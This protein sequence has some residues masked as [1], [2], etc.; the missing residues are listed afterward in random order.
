[1]R[2]FNPSQYKALMKQQAAAAKAKAKKIKVIDQQL[3]GY[4][5]VLPPGVLGQIA[6]ALG[7]DD[8]VK[9]LLWV[10]GQGPDEY[11]YAEAG[12]ALIALPFAPDA[13]L[14][15]YGVTTI[16]TY[17][18]A[19]VLLK[20]ARGTCDIIVATQREAE[21]LIK[22]VWGKKVSTE[23]WTY[24]QYTWKKGQKG[25]A[26][27]HPPEFGMSN[28]PELPHYKVVVNVPKKAGEANPQTLKAHIYFESP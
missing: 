22:D 15:E 18:A 25:V 19:K 21:K 14:A 3:S 26:Q 13:K 5:I 7:V 24:G 20:K 9:L 12:V 16:V 23:T 1:M 17:D 28:H 11:G 10:T 2:L 6:D 27:L 4:D 8:V